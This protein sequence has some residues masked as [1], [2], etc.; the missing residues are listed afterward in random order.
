[1]NTKETKPD[2]T[3]TTE[4][5]KPGT[6]DSAPISGRELLGKGIAWVAPYKEAVV[7]VVAIVGAIF[8]GV[9]WVISY[10]ATQAAVSQL[11][12]RLTHQMTAAS[13]DSKSEIIRSQI[14]VKQSQVQLLALQKQSQGAQAAVNK[15]TAE[16]KELEKAAKEESRK[17]SEQLTLAVKCAT[18][19]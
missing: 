19:K 12:C 5:Q 2:G 8:S 4:E 1:M 16:V 18:A 15:L 7:L 17:S 6:G 3:Q 13:F 9:A 10:F 14:D 11:E